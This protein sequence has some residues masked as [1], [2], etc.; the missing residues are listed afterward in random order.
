MIE[1][2]AQG[3]IPNADRVKNGNRPENEE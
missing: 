3:S 2:T 1:Q